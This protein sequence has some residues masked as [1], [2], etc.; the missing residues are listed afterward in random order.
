MLVFHSR[1]EFLTVIPK[2]Y[3]W[4]VEHHGEVKDKC[5][6]WIRCY[7][8]LIFQT[9]CPDMTDKYFKIICSASFHF[10]HANQYAG[11]TA[12]VRH[13]MHMH[14]GQSCM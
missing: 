11:Y 14:T 7:N 4:T 8:L 9:T 3:Q 1:I 5:G 12:H 10:R 6:K 2:V 13:Q